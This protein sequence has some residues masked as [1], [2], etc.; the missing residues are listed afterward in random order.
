[1]Q[2]NQTD[3]MANP[4]DFDQV[5]K[6]LDQNL[7]E[8]REGI[9]P[10]KLTDE[11]KVEVLSAFDKLEVQAYKTKISPSVKSMIKGK[12]NIPFMEVLMNVLPLLPT[13]LSVSKLKELIDFV[14]DLWGKGLLWF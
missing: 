4:I 7:L 12:P 6:D 1:M 3:Q 8:L 5:I 13:T 11:D 10:E 2:N 9:R 14:G